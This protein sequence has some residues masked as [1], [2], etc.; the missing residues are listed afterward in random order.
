MVVYAFLLE[1]SVPF[2][3]MQEFI[4]W[5]NIWV[6]LVF[7][8]CDWSSLEGGGYM[9]YSSFQ[10]LWLKLLGLFWDRFLWMNEFSSL[11]PDTEQ[12]LMNQVDEHMTLL[13]MVES[14][15][16]CGQP[17]QSSKPVTSRGNSLHCKVF[18]L[19]T[20]EIISLFLTAW[21]LNEL[22]IYMIYNSFILF[23]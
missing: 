23:F 3:N 16:Q 13:G 7:N 5:R 6:S 21:P 11:I 8:C 2:L 9:C 4:F 12:W 18:F 10:L 1:R 20:F 15:F 14:V 19:P 22:Y 17:T